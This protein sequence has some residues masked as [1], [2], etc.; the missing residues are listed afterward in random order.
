MGTDQ[1]DHVAGSRFV[2]VNWMR[3]WVRTSRQPFRYTFF[4]RS[5]SRSRSTEPEGRAAWLSEDLAERLVAASAGCRCRSALLEVRWSVRRTSRSDAYGRRD[6]KIEVFPSVRLGPE[7]E[8]ATLAHPIRFSVREEDLDAGAYQKLVEWIYF[9]IASHVY[10]RSGRT[11]VARSPSAQALLPCRG[12]LLRGGGLLSGRTR[13]RL[14]RCAEAATRLMK[15]YD[16]DWRRPAESRVRRRRD[17]SR[18]GGMSGRSTG[19]EAV[20]SVASARPQLHDRPR[21]KRPHVRYSIAGRSRALGSTVEPGLRGEACYRAGGRTNSRSSG[22]A[23]PARTRH[24]ST[25]A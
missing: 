21:R 22:G 15:L 20:C 8:P 17:G 6:G 7:T 19:D 5:S 23:S 4:V 2:L 14:Q 1:L 16:A 18:N 11:S 24:S 25:R 3:L 10:A 9:S 12:V 13:S